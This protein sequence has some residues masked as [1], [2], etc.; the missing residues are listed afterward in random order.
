MFSAVLQ[1]AKFVPLT[2][3]FF[4]GI[5]NR[6]KGVLIMQEITRAFLTGERALFASENLKITDSI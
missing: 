5:L 3:S 2:S 6:S 1:G 4:G